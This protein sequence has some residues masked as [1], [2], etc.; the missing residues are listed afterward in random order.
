MD[1]WLAKKVANHLSIGQLVGQ[2]ANQLSNGQV[3]AVA[4]DDYNVSR[5]TIIM[6]DRVVHSPKTLFHDFDQIALDT[7]RAQ[8]VLPH[9]DQSN[10]KRVMNWP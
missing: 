8:E 9:P 7:D 4:K 3:F 10:Q 1:K 6:K 5:T 2:V